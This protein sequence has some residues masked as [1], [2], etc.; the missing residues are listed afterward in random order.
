MTTTRYRP[1]L[2]LLTGLDSPGQAAGQPA[3]DEQPI[4]D[5]EPESTDGAEDAGDRD[6]GR[7][8]DGRRV[9]PGSAE[10]VVEETDSVPFVDQRELVVDASEFARPVEDAAEAHARSVEVESDEGGEDEQDEEEDEEG[11]RRGVG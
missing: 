1:S 4:I 9:P 10:Q 11:R 2:I 7:E 8:R 5:A 6:N 3:W